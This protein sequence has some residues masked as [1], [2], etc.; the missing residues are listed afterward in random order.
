MSRFARLLGAAAFTLLLAPSAHAHLAGLKHILTAPGAMNTASGL[1]TSISC[2]NG[3]TANATIGVEVWAANGTYLGGSSSYSLPPQPY[4]GGLEVPL[5]SAKTSILP[6]A[7]SRAT[8]ASSQILAARSLQRVPCGGVITA[9]CNH[10][11]PPRRL[12]V[13]TEVTK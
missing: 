9:A 10:G 7:I 6:R 8:F 5:G 13:Q 2:T 12:Q 4:S 1:G 11:E 3:N